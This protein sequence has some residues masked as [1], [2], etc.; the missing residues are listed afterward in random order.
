MT[1]NTKGLTS[2]IETKEVFM[3]DKEVSGE[4][5][6]GTPEHQALAKSGILIITPTMTMKEVEEIL[7]SADFERALAAYCGA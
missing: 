4:P 7:N 3:A 5:F 2:Y 1:K 6:I